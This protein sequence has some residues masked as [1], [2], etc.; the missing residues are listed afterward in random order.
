MIDRHKPTTTIRPRTLMATTAAVLILSGCGESGVSSV[1]TLVRVSTSPPFVT[2]ASLSDEGRRAYEVYCAGCHGDTGD[3]QGPAAR[4]IRPRPRNFRHANF[5]SSS[6]R[7]GQLPTDEDLS[8]TITE[9]LKGTAMPGWKFLT[10][11]T[12]AALITYIKNFSPR[13]SR[14]DPAPVIP[15][16][17][18]PFRELTDKSGPIARG[19]AV[20]YGYATCWTCHPSYVDTDTINRYLVAME[21]PARDAFREELPQ[22]VGQPDAEGEVVFAPDFRRDVVRSGADVN[23]LYRSIA[24]G[25]TGTAMPTWIDS[26]DVPRERGGGPLVQPQ[27]IWAMAYYVQSLIRQRPA[28][29]TAAMA[30]RYRPR[31]RRQRIL[32]PGEVPTPPAP[33]LDLYTDE[34]FEEEMP[35]PPTPPSGD[36]ANDTTG[37]QP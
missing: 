4:F 30:D 27:D 19:E 23:D 5:K 33:E 13:W 36:A 3:G 24:A 15:Q 12:V 26:M 1:R 32:A 10:P 18:D 31:N 21:N 16:D 22:S 8:R 25:I 14:K 34:L 9:G 29:I 11:R 6:T 17:H 2:K 37:N 20:Y 35:S 28:K 7:S